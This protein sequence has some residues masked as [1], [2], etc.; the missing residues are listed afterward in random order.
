MTF[1]LAYNAPCNTC[2]NDEPHTIVIMDTIATVSAP[3]AVHVF[4]CLPC[5]Q[6][7][8]AWLALQHQGP[9]RGPINEGDAF[10]WID[11]PQRQEQITIL[12]T[13][14][15]EGQTYIRSSGTQDG[16]QIV[17]AS[18]FRRAVV[19]QVYSIPIT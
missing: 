13:Y 18:E 3:G 12:D 11:G 4:Y 10:I 1:E 5:L 15:A 8:T 9:Y 16:V 17:E 2:P 14:K 19:K 6:Q 7:A